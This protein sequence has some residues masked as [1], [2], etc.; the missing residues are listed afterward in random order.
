MSESDAIIRNLNRLVN[1]PKLEYR[2]R[3]VARA[4][5]DYINKLEEEKR[6]LKELLRQTEDNF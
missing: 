5:V 2:H 1:D 4:A 6:E 3:N